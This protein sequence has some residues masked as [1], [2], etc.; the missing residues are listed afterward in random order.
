MLCRKPKPL[1]IECVVRGYMVGSGWND[2]RATGK[3]LRHRACRKG[4]ANPTGFPSPCSRRPPRPPPGHDENITF[5]E[6]VETHRRPAR[7]TAS[8][9][10]IEIYRRAAAYAEPRGILL[11]DTKVR[12]RH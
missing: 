8:R 2:Y 5:D 7:R 3:D 11:A 9:L 4:F 12:I 6:V 10:S 1:P